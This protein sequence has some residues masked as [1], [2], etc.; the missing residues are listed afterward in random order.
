MRNTMQ[1]IFQRGLG[2]IV[3]M[4]GVATLICGCD[5]KDG[6]KPPVVTAEV[7][8]VA[9]AQKTIPVSAP[10]V[11]QTQS[12]HQVDVMARVSGFLEMISYKEGESVQ[13]GQVMFRIDRKPFQAQV[14]AVMAEVES[15]KAQLWTAKANLDRIKPLAELNAASKSDLDNATGSFQAAEA[16]LAEAKARLQKAELDLGYTIIKAPVSGLAGQAMLREGAYVA[17]NSATAKLTYVA[18]LN[19]IWVDFSISQNESTKMRS[20]LTSGR[21]TKPKNDNYSLNLELSDGSLYPQT[22]KLNFAAPTFNRETGTYLIRGEI[23]NPKGIL[24]PGMFVKAFVKGMERPNAILI[25]QKAVQQTANGHVVYV[26]SGTG[27]AELRPVTVGEWVGQDWLIN[28]GLQA[29]D[30]VIVE[31]FQKLAPGAPVKVVT[32]APAADAGKP[33]ATAATSAQK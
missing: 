8:T 27:S 18:K 25:P 11:A 26:V 10:F 9:V 15:R 33:A 1:E 13:E 3:V 21:M 2:T 30:K 16:G 6:S 29:G 22:G 17:A 32:P 14:D 12:C 31:G 19:P 20:E 4:A 7:V 23:A 24:K 28:S 5:S